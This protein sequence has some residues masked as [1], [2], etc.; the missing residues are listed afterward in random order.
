MSFLILALNRSPS[1]DTGLPNSDN[2]CG[3][4][5]SGFSVFNHLGGFAVYA[6]FLLG[7]VSA[8]LNSWGRAFQTENQ[9]QARWQG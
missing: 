9:L 3:I 4:L 1:L 2:V 5:C 6:M 7:G 8:G